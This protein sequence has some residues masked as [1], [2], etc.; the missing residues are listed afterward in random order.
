MWL[1]D[2]EW[3]R[4]LGLAAYAL[5]EH[6]AGV[7]LQAGQSFIIESNFDKELALP[8]FVGLQER[9][10]YRPFQIWCRAEPELLLERFKARTAAGT[11]HPGHQDELV[12]EHFTAEK[13]AA[14]YGFFDIGGV[15]VVW[16]TTDFSAVDYAGLLR[17]V[18][19]FGESVDRKTLTQRRKGA[20]N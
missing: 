7:L 14:R 18:A 16:E 17:Q 10:G 4:R 5:L 19:R 13:L 9:W 11:R 15:Q 12:H 3:S 8:M 1:Q 6:F 20:K 2:R